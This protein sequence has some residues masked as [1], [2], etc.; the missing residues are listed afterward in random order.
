M[1]KC[2]YTVCDTMTNVSCLKKAK[3]TGRESN[4]Q[5]CKWQKKK[6]VRLEKNSWRWYGVSKKKK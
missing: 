1:L 5:S 2:V 6:K 3:E 4:K